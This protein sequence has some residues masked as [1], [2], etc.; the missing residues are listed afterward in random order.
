MNA[1]AAVANTRRRFLPATALL[2]AFTLAALLGLG[3][4]FF[5]PGR[6]PAAEGGAP[7]NTAP[8]A[9]TEERPT[10]SGDTLDSM[11]LPPV[12]TEEE[13]ARAARPNEDDPPRTKAENIPGDAPDETGDDSPGKTGPRGGN[14]NSAAAPDKKSEIIRLFGFVEFRRPLKNMPKWERVLNE[15]KKSGGFE[16]L[17]QKSGRK[18]LPDRW[19]ALKKSADSADTTG[20]MKAVNAFFN[21]WPYRTDM[22]NYGVPDYWATPLEFL[23]RSGDCEDYAII[24]YYALKELGV[25]AGDMRLVVLKDTLRNLDHAVLAVYTDGA[26]YILD[27][28]SNLILSHSRLKHYKPAVSLNESSIWAHIKPK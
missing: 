15:M 11:I 5:L 22:E 13:K 17:I 18:D 8:P 26:A 19:E 27:N 16:A 2:A 12:Y 9:A 28:V 7:A 4:L 25:P 21:Q 10:R 20:K 3:A 24:K 14:G 1:A 23:K 6:A